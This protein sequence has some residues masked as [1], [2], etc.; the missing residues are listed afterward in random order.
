MS[1]RTRRILTTLV[2]LLWSC[3]NHERRD[4]S[5]LT[6]EQ[7]RAIDALIA[8]EAAAHRFAGAAVA[9]I[10]GGKVV[11]QTLAGVS[12]IAHNTP[13][14]AATPFQLASTT[15]T[16]SAS[17]VMTLVGDGKLSLQ[18][19]VGDIVPDL[20]PAWRPVTIQQLLSHTSGLP[21]IVRHAGQL[22][23]VAGTWPEALALVRN[24][25]VQ[26]TPGERWHYTQTNYAL[27][28]LV[29]ERVS[30]KTFEQY[31]TERV[32]VPAGMKHS[33]FAAPGDPRCATSYTPAEGGALRRRALDFPQFV[34]A[35][36]GLCA[37]LDDLAQWNR[38]LDERRIVR[39]Q[40]TE[41]MW[42]NATLTSGQR[43]H[44]AGSSV[45]Y[46]LGWAVDD[47]RGRRWVGHSGG[48]STVFRKYLDQ[49]LTVI[50]LHNGE[51]DPDGLASEIAEIVLS[52]AAQTAPEQTAL[53]DAARSGDTAGI[54]KSLREGADVNAL[55]TRKS[56]NGRRALNWAAANDRAEAIRVLV[57]HGASVNAPN[58]S[59]FT[60]LH[61]A[62]EN[63]AADAAA[64]LL[65]AGADRSAR[66][67]SGETAADVAK[68]KGHQTLV[69]LLQPG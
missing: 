9:V 29:V 8:R 5:V 38:V 22:D 67:A 48:N 15:K 45:G 39:A 32:L 31:A 37:S 56:P 25:P 17:A 12:D 35:A 33:F 63:G 27:L 11:K 46:G 24:A 41:S 19:H 52:G 68:R 1:P 62:A 10:R 47:T 28:A 50:V 7:S 30:G 14:T 57:R 36:G 34:H 40:Q 43:V 49:G 18:T 44:I 53:W 26:F 23:L 42:T 61:H 55:D 51:D 69:S 60:P 54:E 66:N 4:P 3:T 6:G 20:P 13:V 2:I 58:K 64:A 59:G 16:I 65:A 21:D